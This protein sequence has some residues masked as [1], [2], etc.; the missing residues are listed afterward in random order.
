[1]CAPSH[2]I[3][4]QRCVGQFSYVLQDLLSQ[5]KSL[6]RT[7]LAKVGPYL[8]LIE[9]DVEYITRVTASSY[10]NNCGTGVAGDKRR[11]AV[12]LP[13][14]DWCLRVGINVDDKKLDTLRPEQRQPR[15]LSRICRYVFGIAE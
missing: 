4:L 15:I 5:S 9:R 6:L 10:A 11:P 12:G 13:P 7:A 3:M 14:L 1:M 2:F 8:D